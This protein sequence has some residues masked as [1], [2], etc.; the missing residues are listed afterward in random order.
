VLFGVGFGAYLSVDQALITQVL[1]AAA[2]RAKDLGV[3]NIAIVGPAAIGPAIA[4]PIV[5]LG[6]YPLLF[7]ATTIVALLGSAFVWKIKSVS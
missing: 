6:G 5:V 2:D 4:T 1:P 3:I 7:G